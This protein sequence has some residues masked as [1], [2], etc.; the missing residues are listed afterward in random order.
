MRARHRPC[1]RHGLHIRK[2]FF[3]ILPS[4]ADSLEEGQAVALRPASPLMHIEAFLEALTTANQD[5]RVI[6][7]R[8]GNPLLVTKGPSLEVL[9]HAAWFC[10]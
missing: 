2:A 5:G 7:N 10:V 8:Q 9:C 1:E 6:V 3:P 4:S